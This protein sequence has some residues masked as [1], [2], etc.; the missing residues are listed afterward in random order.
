MALETQRQASCTLL[1]HSYYSGF[2]ENHWGA[3]EG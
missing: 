2:L 3:Q 1:P